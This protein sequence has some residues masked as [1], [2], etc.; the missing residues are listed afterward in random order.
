MNIN[1]LWAKSP[2]GKGVEGEPL[3]EHSI[4][5]ARVS[6]DISRHLPLSADDN[7]AVEKVLFLC[8]ALH[9]VGKVAKGFQDSLRPDGLLW[10]RR[11]E[12]L[13][14]LIASHICPDLGLPGLFSILTHHR[15]IPANDDTQERC[16][17][18]EQLPFDQNSIWLELLTDLNTNRHL[19]SPFLT[20][21]FDELEIQCD[22]TKIPTDFNT[23]GIG[24]SKFWLNR[25]YQREQAQK[26]N[27][28]LRRI[29]L[30]RG[31][32]ISSDHLAS[33][34]FRSIPPIPIISESVDSILKAELG[35]KEILP[36]QTRCGQMQNSG[37]VKAPT[38]SGKTLA[39]LLWVARNQSKNGRFYYTLPY[40]ASL[41]AMFNR[42]RKM[43][44]EESVGILH[45]KN[46]AFLYKL[47]EE[48]HS[49]NAEKNA[50]N[51]A[52]LARELYFPIK[53]LTPHQILRVVLRGKGWELGLA[54]FPNACFVFDEIHAYEPLI[55]GLIIASAK[56]LQS[57]GA[58]LLF[59]SATMPRF[60]ENLLKAE[61]G[62][63]ETNVI[64]PNSEDSR[65]RTVLDKK[66][67]R[68]SVCDGSLLSH[69]ND[70]IIEI[71]NNPTT[72]FLIVCNYVATSQEVCRQLEQGNIKEYIL[73]HARFNSED[74]SRIEEAITSKTP[75]RILVATQAIEVSLDIDYDCGYIEPAPI[76]AL[77]QRFGRVNRKGERP[78]ALIT[79]YEKDSVESNRPIYDPTLVSATIELLKSKNVLSENDLVKIL[80][81]VYEKGYT[82]DLLTC[83]EQGLNHPSIKEFDKN[84][85]A[86]TYQDWIESVIE[87]TDG[88]IDVLPFKGIDGNG[89]EV[90]LKDEFVK[91]QRNN[92]YLRAKLLL[93]P[94]RVVQ[95]HIAKKKGFIKWNKDFDEWVTTLKY[96]SK[97]GLDLKNQFDTVI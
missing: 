55:V 56:W 62:I 14:T 30:L 32:L 31:L 97:L 4:Q 94:I 67:H 86:G 41:N 53:V 6:R 76:D 68:I 74:R 88:Q 84:L 95:F 77:A 54:E 9:D 23:D 15:S 2:K 80:N 7:L 42:I 87:K 10:G 81:S 40:T 78:P 39:I 91:R 3:L 59:A 17:P 66:R 25:I 29:S 57:M 13:S 70:I 85:I 49:V 34:G 79:V 63:P 96:S 61:L 22:L 75:P 38:G 48:D 64:A 26:Q 90:S 33:A 28:D 93:V 82:G 69:L 8:C 52:G 11:H 71:R 89:N 45:H 19:L 58:K 27:E 36:F 16:L 35:S 46:A 24:I 18:W 60:L 73:L 37:I 83:Y 44:P 5:T 72:K 51:L 43:F 50:K 65:D 21:L 12:I 47:Y 1:F 20:K 92:E